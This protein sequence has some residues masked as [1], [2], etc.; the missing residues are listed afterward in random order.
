MHCSSSMNAA[1][2]AGRGSLSSLSGA[3]VVDPKHCRPVVADYKVTPLDEGDEGTTM[4]DD[5]IKGSGSGGNASSS[6]VQQDN[7]NTMV[8]LLTP[9]LCR[10]GGLDEGNKNYWH[11]WFIKVIRKKYRTIWTIFPWLNKLIKLCCNYM[12]KVWIC[13]AN[14]QLI[15]YTTIHYLLHIMFIWSSGA[16]FPSPAPCTQCVSEHGTK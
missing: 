5:D 16:D 6:G 13:S 8:E 12:S 4:D 2:A 11:I 7:S 9:F 3:W 10:T 14:L 1:A 15:H